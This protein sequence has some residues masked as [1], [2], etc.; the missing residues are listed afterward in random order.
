MDEKR[1]EDETE[2]NASK[3][4]PEQ[5]VAR[6]ISVEDTRFILD[7]LVL[8]GWV[9]TGVLTLTNSITGF[10]SATIWITLGMVM[11]TL[12]DT[13]LYFHWYTYI[14]SWIGLTILFLIGMA[15]CL[16]VKH[17]LME[18]EQAARET[19]TH[20]WLIPATDKT[21]SS[22]GCGAPKKAL[23]ILLGGSAVWTTLNDQIILTLYRY[24]LLRLHR[25][26]NALQIDADIF[27][28]DGI[29][30]VH[31]ERNEFH[32][33][34]GEHQ[35]S[36]AESRD[37]DRS[38]L[39]VRGPQFQ[40]VLFIRYVDPVTLKIR[41]VFYVPNRQVGLSVTDTKIKLFAPNGAESGTLSYN[42]SGWDHPPRNG[43]GAYDFNWGH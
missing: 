32:L 29:G 24:P 18:S 23:L 11:L 43:H 20:G 34:K 1:S 7:R 8:I 36:Y 28:S 16:S 37:A 9:I 15:L 17:A 5:Q 33:I 10:A 2:S 22:V 13:I 31:I 4:S 6:R 19:A 40:E 12:C 3:K 25:K 26:N 35:V 38:T 41:G 14:L 30:M 27:D 42:C 39:L 21:P